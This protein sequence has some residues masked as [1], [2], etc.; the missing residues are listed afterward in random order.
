MQNCAQIPAFML[1]L[2]PTILTLLFNTINVALE[3]DLAKIFILA[4]H[5]TS[6]GPIPLHVAQ[7]TSCLVPL[8]E[9]NLFE[10]QN[11]DV[12]P[13]WLKDGYHYH[14]RHNMLFPPILALHI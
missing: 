8:D 7:P 12:T 1:R 2:S 14:L 9:L 6:H 3:R 11:I 10:C 5:F 13:F 4:R